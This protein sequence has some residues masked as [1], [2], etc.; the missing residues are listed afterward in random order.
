MNIPFFTLKSPIT[1]LQTSIDRFIY[2]LISNEYPELHTRRLFGVPLSL[3]VGNEFTKQDIKWRDNGK[4]S[5][6]I[7]DLHEY[8]PLC[9]ILI[10]SNSDCCVVQGMERIL[11]NCRLPWVTVNPKDM[12]EKVSQLIHRVIGNSASHSAKIPSQPMEKV[13]VGSVRC[14]FRELSEHYRVLEQVGLSEVV[15]TL[16]FDTRN[17]LRVLFGMSRNESH[18]ITKIHMYRLLHEFAARSSLDLLILGNT[19]DS[20]GDVWW[21]MLAVEIDGPVHEHDEK[22]KL[23]DAKKDQICAQALLPLLRITLSKASR[24]IYQQAESE[25]KGD[26]SIA[27]RID[28]D[29]IRY[30]IAVGLE[31]GSLHNQ[32]KLQNQRRKLIALRLRAEVLAQDGLSFDDAYELALNELVSYEQEWVEEM[33]DAF[34]DEQIHKLQLKELESQYRAMYGKF[35]K[36]KVIVNSNGELSGRLGNDEI[37]PVKAF[38]SIVGKRDM[39]THLR[40]FGRQWLLNRALHSTME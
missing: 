30:M 33:A 39:G 10:E 3:V 22:Q 20:E 6:L 26:N 32:R 5:V 19:Y 18:E 38:L 2:S 29:L 35:P 27:N 14:W 8:T 17:D 36:I 31:N 1:H 4:I 40:N 11:N 34:V 9:A 23:R 16:T 37:P 28:L 15:E 12:K 25:S 21:P 13:L 7:V 24:N